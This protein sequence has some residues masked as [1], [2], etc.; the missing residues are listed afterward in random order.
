MDKLTKIELMASKA[1]IKNLINNFASFARDD[2]LKSGKNAGFKNSVLNF[3][4]E[5]ADE[6]L[7]HVMEHQPTQELIKIEQAVATT[8]YSM[9]YV[10]FNS[11]A[12]KIKLPDMPEGSKISKT[13]VLVLFWAHL[14]SNLFKHKE[15]FGE[16]GY[17]G[18]YAFSNQYI[19][20]LEEKVTFIAGSVAKEVNIEL[21]EDFFCAEDF[22]DSTAFK[23]EDLLKYIEAS[24]HKDVPSVQEY[25][26]EVA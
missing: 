12:E 20:K 13:K 15:V 21:D 17:I 8:L 25:F 4:K 6:A 5:N 9:Y 1:V 18:E 10:C 11:N 19:D 24:F 7:F 14:M 26:D 16:K 3:K 2:F 22:I 23:D